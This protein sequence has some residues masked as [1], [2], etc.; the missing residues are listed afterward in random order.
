MWGVAIDS[1]FGQ[2]LVFY[3]VAIWVYIHRPRSMIYTF[4]RKL[5]YKRSI[6]L[7]EHLYSS[8]NERENTKC[9]MKYRNN[10]I[11]GHLVSC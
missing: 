4:F 7:L 1:G 2:L 8:K 5:V 6:F 10:L 11:L 9:V 3:R